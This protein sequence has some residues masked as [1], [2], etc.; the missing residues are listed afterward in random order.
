M[1]WRRKQQPTPE[2]S[3]GESR[4][5]GAWWATVR[6]VVKSRTRLTDGAH[7][8]ARAFS[9]PFLTQVLPE[10]GVEFAVL[11]AALYLGQDDGY[12]GEQICLI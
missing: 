10:R 5:G 11:Y 6:G 9:G 8:R 7:R 12:T 4:D 2:F 1:P 3:P